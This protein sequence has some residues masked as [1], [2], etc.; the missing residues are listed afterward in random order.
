MMYTAFHSGDA[1]DC[2]WKSHV[3]AHFNIPSSFY[4]KRSL[5][6]LVYNDSGLSTTQGGILFYLV[7][8]NMMASL[9][10]NVHVYLF[11][12]ILK[13]TANRSPYIFTLVQKVKHRVY[14]IYA[15]LSEALYKLFHLK[16]TC[17][18]CTD[19][20]REKVRSFQ[21]VTLFLRYKP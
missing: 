12:Y 14:K 6:S 2:C 21:K 5:R 11:H 3:A 16:M 20:A 15:F 7:K 17:T 19:E 4:N 8:T 18:S 9:E 1:W 10:S 13:P